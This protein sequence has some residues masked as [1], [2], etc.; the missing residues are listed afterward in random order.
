HAFDILIDRIGRIDQQS[1]A[2]GCGEKLAQ[3]AQL[4][5]AQLRLEG[6][7]AGHIAARPGK[8]GDEASLT[9]SPAALNTIGTVAVAA[10]AATAAGMGAATITAT[11]RR[12]SS[13]ASA[14]SRSYCPSAQRY[15]I[16]TLCLST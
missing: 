7:H 10:L 11:G 16:V 3:Q 4:L 15:S 9:G 1:D 13:A 12:P 2:G 14:G 6:M 5:C 8:T